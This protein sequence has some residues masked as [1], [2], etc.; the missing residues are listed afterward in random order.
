MLVG[1][2]SGMELCKQSPPLLPW[3]SYLLWM[4]SLHIMLENLQQGLPH[5]AHHHIRKHLQNMHLT[6][7]TFQQKGARLRPL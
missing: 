2:K 6:T 4:R 7:L 5:A 3:L 1:L